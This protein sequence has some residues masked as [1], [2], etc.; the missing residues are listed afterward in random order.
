MKD[1]VYDIPAYQDILMAIK[2]LKI[3]KASAQSDFY[4]S[5]RRALDIAI[6]IL[7][8]KAEDYFR[9]D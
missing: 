1:N 8:D 9:Q 3:A 5:R 4:A 6:K 2:E 7:E